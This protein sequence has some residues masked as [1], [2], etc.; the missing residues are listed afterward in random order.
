VGGNETIRTNIRLIAST[1]RD[2]KKRIAED[3]FREDLYYRLSGFIIHL[4]PLRER[5]D[6]IRLLVR[7]FIGKY[8][9]ELRR[10]CQE[11]AGDAM[12]S[13]CRYSWPGNVRELQ[14][15]I[16]QAVLRSS[17][18]V[19]LAT[20]LPRLFDV[21][22]PTQPNRTPSSTL[23]DIDAFLRERLGPDASD[24]YAELER[25]M[26]R[27]FLPRVLEYAGGNQR[28]AS[29]LLGMARQ[30][31]REKLRDCGLRIKLS[32]EQ[33]DSAPRTLQPTV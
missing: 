7:H 15:V 5:G 13:L 25:E 31:L 12:E 32:A 33:I 26:D 3:L 20:F 24:L 18:Q 19:L 17:G 29:R 1:H 4:P 23:F 28:L 8:V 11:I 22:P 30:T 2:L 27:C 9:Q 10:D 14:N 16:K 21:E 6:D